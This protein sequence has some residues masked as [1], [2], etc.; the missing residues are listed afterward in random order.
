MVGCCLRRR[1]IFKTF[2]TTSD[3]PKSCWRFS[4]PSNVKQKQRSAHNSNLIALVCRAAHKQSL[5]IYINDTWKNWNTI[6]KLLCWCNRRK[7]K[8]RV[9]VWELLRDAMPIK[10]CCGNLCA[11]EKNCC[12]S[13]KCSVY[14]RIFSARAQ[15]WVNG[16]CRIWLLCWFQL[17]RDSLTLHPSSN[18]YT[19][20]IVFMQET[21]VCCMLQSVHIFVC[22]FAGWI[23]TKAPK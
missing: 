11:R 2:F 8:C 6:M 3:N 14:T 21:V 16:N 4:L 13:L 17:I 20:N 23:H 15:M 1:W 18:V 5:C 9:L 22:L 12:S 19:L 10:G 7:K